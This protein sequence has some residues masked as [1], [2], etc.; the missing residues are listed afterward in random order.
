[1]NKHC[2]DLSEI[3]KEAHAKMSAI[4]LK[5]INDD[6]LTTEQKNNII[7]VVNKLTN[8]MKSAQTLLEYIVSMTD[9]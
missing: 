8:S 2:K 1:M 6:N 7:T 9:I 3:I 4:D 5:I